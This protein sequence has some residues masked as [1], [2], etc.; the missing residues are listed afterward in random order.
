MSKY[1]EKIMDFVHNGEKIGEL[2]RRRTAEEYSKE[3]W[4]LRKIR[5]MFYE[6]VKSCK[7][8]FR[9]PII[10][11][12]LCI[13]RSNEMRVIV[14]GSRFFEN[15]EFVSSQLDG[16]LKDTNVTQIICGM[17]NGVDLLGKRYAKEKGL[18]VCEFP[19]DWDKYKKA[20]GPIRNRQMA[21][22]GL[23]LILFWDGKSPGSKNMLETMKRMNK[24]IIEIIIPKELL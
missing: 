7:N 19:A 1:D 13:V 22:H 5:K 20:A 8:T 3:Y 21:E 9:T 2:V 18:I 4:E 24:K 12:K 17:A 15:Y 11:N 16:I 6:S 14:A 10:K 23:L